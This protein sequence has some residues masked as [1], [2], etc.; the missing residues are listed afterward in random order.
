MDLCPGVFHGIRNHSI[1]K[2][3]CTCFNVLFSKDINC[4]SV[5]IPMPFL[6]SYILF[7]FSLC[8]LA[9]D[10]GQGMSWHA[11]YKCQLRLK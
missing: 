8:S 7:K 3:K 9:K 6:I 11:D 2:I 5:Y 1:S 4:L 10:N